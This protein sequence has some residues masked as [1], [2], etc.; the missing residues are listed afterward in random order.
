MAATD[1]NPATGKTV[2]KLG[3]EYY[4]IIREG[5]YAYYLYTPTREDDMIRY[6]TKNQAIKRA[7]ALN[8][9]ST[10]A[11]RQAEIDAVTADLQAILA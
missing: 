11:K 10:T 4:T 1:Y 7:R 8:R 5:A 9:T 6:R 3:G 2:L